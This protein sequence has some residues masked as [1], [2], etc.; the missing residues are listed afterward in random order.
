M[1]VS[2]PFLCSLAGIAMTIFAWYGPWEW[3]AAPAFSVLNTFFSGHYDE[4][5]YGPRA[6]VLVLLI[7]VN[8]GT[9]A[10]AAFALLFFSRSIATLRR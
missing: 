1:R 8:V 6:A 2:R 4:L 3:P 9:W 5:A 7:V 10:L